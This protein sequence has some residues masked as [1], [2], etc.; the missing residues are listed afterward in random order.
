MITYQPAFDPYHAAFRLLRLRE[1]V[2]DCDPIE[3]DRL[4]ILDFYLTFPFLLEG[5][6][7]RPEDRAFRSVA[8]RYQH[9]VPFADLPE[10]IVLFE[11]MELPHRSAVD[12]FVNRD[13]LRQ[14]DRAARVAF[15]EEAVI[16]E[17]VAARA[18]VANQEQLD[19]MGVLSAFCERYDFLGADGLKARTGLMEFRYDPI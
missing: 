11:Y 10:Q 18:E 1:L 2:S 5:V 9:L 19:L 14:D 17:E 15:N 7:F 16:P 6:R 3:R 4:R 8:R 12:T 13:W